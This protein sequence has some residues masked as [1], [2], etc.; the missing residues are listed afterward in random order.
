[1]AAA[2]AYPRHPQPRCNATYGHVLWSGASPSA[3]LCQG[4][5]CRCAS[6]CWRSRVALS[7][8]PGGSRGH[9]SCG[10]NR[11]VGRSRY[12][13]ASDG[14][15][16]QEHRPHR[17]S[18]VCFFRACRSDQAFHHVLRKRRRWTAQ[19]DA[20]CVRLHG[21]NSKARAFSCSG[22]RIRST[23]AAVR[24]RFAECFCFM[25]GCAGCAH[26]ITTPQ[27]PNSTHSITMRTICNIE[28]CTVLSPKTTKNI[29]SRTIYSFYTL[30]S[31]TTNKSMAM[32]KCEHKQNRAVRAC[33]WHN[34]VLIDGA[35]SIK[36]GSWCGQHRARRLVW[37][38]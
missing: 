13:R 34:R 3:R 19:A 14:S 16:Q 27:Q 33:R 21:G 17:R 5:C 22:R 32:F 1:M 35:A 37:P 7:P 29:Y 24:T 20:G 4:E 12:R 2:G 23:K 11:R 36:L 15:V 6:Q 10:Q 28:V 9:G 38:T 8:H 26:L 31:S 30:I 25:W 18:S